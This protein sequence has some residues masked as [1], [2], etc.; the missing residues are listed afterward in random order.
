MEPNVTVG[1]TARTSQEG[2]LAS[3]R[4][5]DIRLLVLGWVA[6]VKP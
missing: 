3:F 1:W 4:I 2:T 5:P 6:T